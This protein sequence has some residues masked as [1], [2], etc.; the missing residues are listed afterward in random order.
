[1]KGLSYHR[2]IV[3]GNELWTMN[4][5][6]QKLISD[7][8]YFPM[9]AWQKEKFN[10]QKDLPEATIIAA[11]GAGKS[12][13]IIWCACDEIINKNRKQII[14]IPM[15]HSESSYRNKNILFNNEKVDFDIQ[16][17]CCRNRKNTGKEFKKFLKFKLKRAMNKQCVNLGTCITSHVNFVMT[18]K[19][20]SDEELKELL[21]N[22]TIHL[23]EFH[24]SS[25]GEE[26]TEL[27]KLIDRIMRIKP[28]SCRIRFYT[29][30]AFRGDNQKLISD[31]FWNRIPR[32]I[33]P[34][35]EYIQF[36]EIEK[37]HYKNIIYN[38]ITPIQMSCNIIK[39]HKNRHHLIILPSLKH[40]FRINNTL[41]ELMTE[42]KKIYNDNEILD[43]VT[44]RTQKVNKELL[45]KY[46]EKY[47]VVVA[48]NLF[49][50]ASDWPPCDFV[51]NMNP[52]SS[53]TR[54]CQ[55]F[56][57]PMRKYTGK[58][59]VWVFNY[60]MNIREGK[61][62]EYLSDCLNATI[63][64]MQISSQLF[65][66]YMK[67][68]NFSRNRNIP[69]TVAFANFITP[70]VITDLILTSE[71]LSR[72]TCYKNDKSK[73]FERVAQQVSNKWYVKS[74]AST[75]ISKEDFK[76][77]LKRE[78]IKH[79]TT[80][81]I[82]KILT[83]LID[84]SLFRKGGFDKII[85][86]LE[87]P[88]NLIFGTKDPLS[89]KDF[90]ELE[91]IARKIIEEDE[92]QRKDDC[93]ELKIKSLLW[94]AT[95]TVPQN[96]P[97]ENSDLTGNWVRTN[98]GI[99]KVLQDDGTKIQTAIYKNAFVNDLTLENDPIRKFIVIYDKFKYLY[100]KENNT[101]VP[102]GSWKSPN[103]LK[104]A[105]NFKSRKINLQKNECT[106]VF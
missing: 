65:T 45:N 91:K 53:M 28:E 13:L 52:S 39:K 96:I 20:I 5:T 103:A 59:T 17:N 16:V 64:T 26:G 47:K 75:S 15:T 23:D 14:L 90:I 78:L 69:N 97:R 57:R 95:E 6:E 60:I 80:K 8:E 100:H 85:E 66:I 38:D 70:P 88:G 79:L 55:V 2:K 49:N 74:T 94:N 24:H 25:Y 4:Q 77:G 61:Y 68:I 101:W 92:Q 19:N 34:F 41:N 104:Y 18:F 98:K 7:P 30:T 71:S 36:T 63:A 44:K 11:G 46:P 27:G 82:N 1:M 35:N 67:R 43:W 29:A 72:M 84:A 83:G 37:I 86:E 76:E 81:K 50:E 87:L 58:K 99:G 40:S 9:R 56:F 32:F 22:T 42:L 33:Y 106:P 48:C 102:L 93:K 21:K 10:D 105:K 62:R 89:D 73:F 3:F 54:S 12:L 51:H 31:E